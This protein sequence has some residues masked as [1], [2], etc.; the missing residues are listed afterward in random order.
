MTIIRTVIKLHIPH[1]DAP[2][3]RTVISFAPL[4]ASSQVGTSHQLRMADTRQLEMQ[5]KWTL[6]GAIA[7]KASSNLSE[8]FVGRCLK[9]HR[10]VRA[11]IQ[12]I[13]QW[14]IGHLLLIKFVILPHVQK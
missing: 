5:C 14:R 11:G 9:M 6:S 1:C 4:S 2:A 3:A 13:N 12:Q 8:I 10:N 7:S